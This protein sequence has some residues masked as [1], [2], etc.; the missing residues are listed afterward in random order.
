M[1]VVA[2]MMTDRM[3][4][5]VETIEQLPAEAQDELAEHIASALDEAR[6]QSLL[7]DPKRLER[8]RAL[9]DEAMHDE[10]RPFPHPRDQ[11]IAE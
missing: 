9:A 2:T 3:R 4:A 7:Q 6:W 1:E 5:L 11:E 8:L 10:V